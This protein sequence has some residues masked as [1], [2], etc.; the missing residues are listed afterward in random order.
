MDNNLA[1]EIYEVAHLTGTFTLRSGQISN[2]YFDKYLFES[3]PAVLSKVADQLALL[4]PDGIEVLAGLEMGG[5]PIATALSL[6]SNIPAAFVRKKAKEYG[7]CKLA[8]GTNIEGK[9][10][11]IIEDVVTTGGQVILSANDL[12]SAGAIVEDMICVIERNPEGRRNL[13]E[14]GLKVHSLFKMEELIA[15]GK[16]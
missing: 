3:N 1:K 6:K 12:R 8:E 5:I 2:E 10:I 14:I 15:A 9:R 11:C 4:I 13:E 16:S 7:T